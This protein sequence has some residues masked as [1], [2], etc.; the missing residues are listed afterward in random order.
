MEGDQ[1]TEIPTATVGTPSEILSAELVRSRHLT[2]RPPVIVIRGRYAEENVSGGQQ[3]V[4]G[5]RKAA[6][7]LAYEILEEVRKWPEA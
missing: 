3:I 4:I 2:G 7:N 6:K 1:M 5:D